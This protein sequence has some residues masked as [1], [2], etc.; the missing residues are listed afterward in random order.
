MLWDS[1]DSFE[2]T[3]HWSKHMGKNIVTIFAEKMFIL[4]LGEIM[5]N[6]YYSSF[7]F[8]LGIE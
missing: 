4:V 2:Q 1:K 7:T 3:K 5:Q 8:A 6:D